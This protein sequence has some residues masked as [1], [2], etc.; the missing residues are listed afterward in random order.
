MLRHVR[1]FMATVALGA[2]ATACTD[3]TAPGEEA[4]LMVAGGD[5]QEAVTPDGGGH[6]LIGW[7][8]MP[9]S[10]RVRLTDAGGAPLP[11][12]SVTWSSTVGSVSPGVSTTNEDGEAAAR[13]SLY[14]PSNG[15]APVGTFQAVAM[16][17]GASATFT[18]HARAGV[19]LESIRFTPDTVDIGPGAAPVSVSVRLSDDRRDT[20]L[21]RVHVQLYN[22][23]A[24]ST[25]FQ[26]TV[27]DLALTG[28]TDSGS[29]WTG[30][31]IMPADAEQG[32]W[33]LGRIS[34]TWGCGGENRATLL[35]GLLREFGLTHELHVVAG[36][37]FQ[38][39]KN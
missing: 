14:S 5:D 26:S 24:T 34:F 23:S 10:L 13:W 28:E 3:T 30:S 2:L 38:P 9:D 32:A 36:S 6:L 16:A 19:T 39:P 27:S 25:D 35:D 8:W 29:E 33:S 4:R 1:G 37:G 11:G 18:G 15:W 31:F 7:G 21:E 20:A 12:R 22:P 17:P